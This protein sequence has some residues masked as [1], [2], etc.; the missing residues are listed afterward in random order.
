MKFTLRIIFVSTVLIAAYIA[1]GIASAEAQPVCWSGNGHCYEVIT[2]F[3]TRWDSAKTQA[4]SK[5]YLGQQGHLASINSRKENDFLCGLLGGSRYAYSIGGERQPTA[6]GPDEGWQWVTGETW[7]FTNWGPG[8][9]FDGIQDV[10]GIQPTD[11]YWHDYWRAEGA[12]GGY[13]VEYDDILLFEDNFDSPALSP[14]WISIKPSQWIQDGWLHTL[15]TNPGRDSFAVVNDGNSMWTDYTYRVTADGLLSMGGAVDDFNLLFRTRDVNY[16]TYGIDGFYYRLEVGT[17]GYTLW[18]FNGSASSSTVLFS[19]P[20]RFDTSRPIVVTITVTGPRI[21][22]WFDGTPVIDLVDPEPLLYGG[23]GIGAVWESEARFDDISVTRQKTL[24]DRPMVQCPGDVNNDGIA[25]IA[26][27]T[28]NGHTEIKSLNGDLISQFALSGISGV[29]D[30]EVMPDMNSNGSPE[31]VALGTG[32][33]KAEVWDTLTARQ[34]SEVDF[35]PNLMPIDLELVTDQTA[36]SIPE[37]ANLA[38]GSLKVEVKDALTAVQV[39]T[40]SFNHYSNAKDLEVYPDLNGNGSP[41]LAV[42][43]DNSDRNKADKIEIRDLSTGE[44]VQNIWLGKG[45]QVMRQELITDVNGNGYEEVAVLQVNDKDGAVNVQLRD[46]KTGQGLGRIGFDRKYPPTHLF[47][48]RDVNDNGADEVVVF[49]QRFNGGNQKV[50]IKDSRTGTL[51][52]RIYFDKN[53]AGQDMATCPDINGNG[54]KELVLLSQRASDGKLKA[55]V[56]DAGTGEKIGV[57]KF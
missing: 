6:I 34:L 18:R 22:V 1:N 24:P 13:I 56:K 46:S 14:E 45:W 19:K 21:Q 35:D 52:R 37:L 29:V 32:S 49:G 27:V 9:P 38:Q 23:I 7:S 3:G 40:V 26:V 42:L 57:V 36:N 50:Q 47:T 5:T 31:L 28:P 30:V 11:C 17:G 12:F 2:T 10:A 55:T 53:F 8:Q 4:E 48:L 43:A 44:I 39:N 54:T 15:D 33:V 51:I 16:A 25:E 20:G 41:D